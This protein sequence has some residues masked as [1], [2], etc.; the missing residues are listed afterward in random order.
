MTSS[1]PRLNSAQ[2]QSATTVGS[3]ASRESG[4][5]AVGQLLLAVSAWDDFHKGEMY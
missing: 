3:D 5:T 2:Q 1:V 4:G